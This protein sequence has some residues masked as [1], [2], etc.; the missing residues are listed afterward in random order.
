MNTAAE[1]GKQT[2][3]G[4]AGWRYGFQNKLDE[5]PPSTGIA[6]PVT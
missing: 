6:A 4:E 5:K 1:S 3:Q 2:A